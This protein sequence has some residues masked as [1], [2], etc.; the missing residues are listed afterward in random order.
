VR[1]RV[2]DE[3][4]QGVQ[5][6]LQR[7]VGRRVRRRLLGA[8]AND[9]EQAGDTGEA[10]RAGMEMS[11]R[12]LSFCLALACA[13]R[14]RSARANANEDNGYHAAHDTGK[15][16]CR[17]NR[18]YNERINPFSRPK[19]R[20]SEIRIPLSTLFD[21]PPANGA[22]PSC[23]TT[24]RLDDC[25][26]AWSVKRRT[27]WSTPAAIACRSM[28]GARGRRSSSISGLADDRLSWVLSI[29]RLA[30]HFRCIAYDLPAGNRRRRHAGPAASRRSRRGLFALLD[31]LA[32]PRACLLGSS[33]G[34]T[35][36]LAAAHQQPAR[37]D[38]VIVA[39]GFA[40]RP[41][42]LAENLL[43]AFARYWPWQMNELPMREETLRF[44][45]AGPFRRQP[46]RS[47]SSS[48]SA[49]VLRP[50]PRSR[51]RARILHRLDI[52]P[53]LPQVR[54]PVMMICGDAD[55]LVGKDCEAELL[56]R[57]AARVARGDRGMR[58][59]AAVHASG[60]LTEIVERYLG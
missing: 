25:L 6:A 16:R 43:A 49:A 7:R 57:L 42:A 2:D 60:I 56:A 38:R 24:L 26:A 39:G 54:Q 34:S 21:A 29:A 10:K 12:F 1:H 14:N 50:W 18:P 48:S 44:A 36:A 58:P 9:E 33:F 11:H 27:T 22:A 37:V 20:V 51:A 52:R 30:Q 15:R 3:G 59:L 28:P 35:I 55:P 46:P 17:V 19:P 47:G 40:R 41:L 53:L 45:H 31:S 13:C 4:P 32:I 23:A 5:Q 8:A